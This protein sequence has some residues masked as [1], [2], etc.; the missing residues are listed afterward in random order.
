M[1]TVGAP[2]SVVVPSFMKVEPGS[3]NLPIAD[4]SKVPTSEPPA[5]DVDKAAA[6]W[7]DAFNKTVKSGNY[8]QIADLFLEEGFWRDHLGLAWDFHT[9]QG[10]KKI[11]EFLKSS[12]AGCRVKSVAIDKSSPF[13]APHVSGFDGSGKIKG[14]E[15]FLLTET[16]V[17][18]GR[19]VVRLVQDG[20]T[21]KAFTLFTSM[22]EL[23]GHEETVFGRRPQGVE[24][25]GHPGRKNW[26]ERREAESNFENRDPAV[27]II[28]NKSSCVGSPMALVVTDHMQGLARAVLPP[29]PD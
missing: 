2:Q 6:E 20:H 17:G 24:H 29:L 13:R 22:Q 3:I 12:K 27:L 4:L 7:V 8:S 16:D 23:K 15:T 11:V 5:A 14:V 19:G 9:L 28:G 18:S 10:P 25:G 26:L 21:W 1:A